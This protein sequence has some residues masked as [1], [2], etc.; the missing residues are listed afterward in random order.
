M[1]HT[2]RSSTASI[3]VSLLSLPGIIYLLGLGA[4]EVGIPTRAL[5]I[6]LVGSGTLAPIGILGALA[7]FLAT[8]SKNSAR[9]NLY[10]IVMIALSV[11]GAWLRW[12]V[13]FF[14]GY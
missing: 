9:M 4:I 13:A 11:W 8:G 14:V 1:K 3:L 5:E 10:L 6:P 2:A 12:R 7:V